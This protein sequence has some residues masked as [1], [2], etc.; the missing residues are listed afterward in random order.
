M[1]YRGE[2]GCRADVGGASTW[3]LG[4]RQV[5][6]G[7]RLGDGEGFLEPCA[8]HTIEMSQV[9]YRRVR[10]PACQRETVARVTDD[11]VE[12]TECGLALES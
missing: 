6:A 7:G 5:G 4:A 10:C 3:A 1:L 11:R 12:C 8:G 2:V 9:I